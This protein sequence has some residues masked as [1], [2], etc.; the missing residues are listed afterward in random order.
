MA[1]G[2][3]V[4]EGNYFGDVPQYRSLRRSETEGSASTILKNF[5]PHNAA[6]SRSDAIINNPANSLASLRRNPPVLRN[7]AMAT[8]QQLGQL[9]RDATP[10]TARGRADQTG[11]GFGLR[12]TQNAAYSEDFAR[13]QKRIISKRGLTRAQRTSQLNA[14][15]TAEVIRQRGYEGSDA[16][17]ALD[18]AESATRRGLTRSQRAQLGTASDQILTSLNRENAKEAVVEK[19][20]S[21]RLLEE[22]DLYGDD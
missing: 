5:D 11:R 12:A 4:Q 19:S 20:F 15:E 22:L 1:N 2:K 3:I 10:V 13:Q 18:L 21:E 7:P 6:R 9:S 16:N 14:L 17:Q 8:Q